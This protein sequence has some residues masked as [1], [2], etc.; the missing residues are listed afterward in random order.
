MLLGVRLEG[1]QESGSGH[2][3]AALAL[4]G[5]D[6]DG[7]DVGPADLLLHLGRRPG[8]DL[9]ARVRAVVEGIG[10]R[11]AVDLG[12]EGAEGVLVRHVLGGQRHREIRAAVVPVVEH[13]D[14]L[15]LGVRACDLD[16]V[17]H[18]L[19]A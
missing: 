18:C 3:E 4:D 8:S 17:L 14:G 16:G 15:A 5:L 7:S 19:G 13:H 11:H 9:R 1:G 12:R 10:H 6:D 2:D